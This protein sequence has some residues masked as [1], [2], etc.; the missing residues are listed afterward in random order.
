MKKATT[1][2]TEKKILFY[3]KEGKN[4]FEEIKIRNICVRLFAHSLV[5]KSNK[6]L[7]L[8]PLLDVEDVTNARCKIENNYFLCIM[9]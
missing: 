8:L 4:M 5:R 1:T 9:K 2:A 6:N 7:M 3:S